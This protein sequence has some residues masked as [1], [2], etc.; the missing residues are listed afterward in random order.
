M[1]R[2]I[3]VN[4]NGKISSKV[5]NTKSR[6]VLIESKKRRKREVYAC[7]CVWLW[8][9]GGVGAASRSRLGEPTSAVNASPESEFLKRQ[10]GKKKTIKETIGGKSSVGRGW[11]K[12]GSE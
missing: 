1:Q 2:E 12:V 7:V 10:K 9:G 3:D 6:K 8:G 5:V 4:I 11:V